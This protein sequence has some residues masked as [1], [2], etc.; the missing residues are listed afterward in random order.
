MYPEPTNIW[1]QIEYSTLG[2]TVAESTWMFPTLESLHV[3]ALVTASAFEPTPTRRKSTMAIMPITVTSAITWIVSSVG[4]IQVDSAMV[5]P[6]EEYSIDSQML[7]GSG[8]S[9]IS[10]P[11]QTGA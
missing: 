10:V 2:I 4:N 9:D 7:V 3:V 8:Y 5:V 1:E 6:S 11:P